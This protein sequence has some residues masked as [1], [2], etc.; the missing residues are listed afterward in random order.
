MRAPLAFL[1]GKLNFEKEFQNIEVK[2]EG[3]DT[4]ITAEPKSGN[5]PYSKVEFVVSPIFEIHKLRI[6]NLDQ[7]VLDFAFDSEKVTRLWRTRCFNFERRRGRR[8]SRVGE[9]GKVERGQAAPSTTCASD[10]G[11][12]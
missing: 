7:S 2:P 9:G 1:L 5:L 10:G 3:A 6:H 8:W 11:S 12:G 4:L